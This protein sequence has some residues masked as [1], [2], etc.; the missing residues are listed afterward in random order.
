MIIV[1]D[2]RVELY[3]EPEEVMADTT[4][5]LHRILL[6]YQDTLTMEK[7]FENVKIQIKEIEKMEKK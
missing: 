3:G 1:E 5:L 2:G 7:L 4:I 6:K